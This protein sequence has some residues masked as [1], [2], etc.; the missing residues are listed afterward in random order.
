MRTRR[1]ATSSAIAL[2]LLFSAVVSASAGPLPEVDASA[3]LVPAAPARAQAARARANASLARIATPVSYDTRFDVPTMLWAVRG[4]APVTRSAAR[5]MQASAEAAAR[6][7]LGSVAGLYR[8]QAEDVA[9]A[10][11]RYVHD[12]GRGGVLVAFRQSI[13]GVEV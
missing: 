12:T 11:L 2:L 7:H 13:D 9:D 6:R 10:S 4:Q 1:P 8:L 3:G 5:P